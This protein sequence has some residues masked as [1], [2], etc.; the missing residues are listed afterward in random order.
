MLIVPTT[1]LRA[2]TSLSRLAELQDS[3]VSRHQLHEHGYDKDAIR[4]NVAARRWQ[5]IGRSV[6]VLHN[7]PLT[8]HQRKWAGVIGQTDGALAGLSAA[9]EFGFHGFDDDTVHIL[10][11]HGAR[12]RPLPGVKIHISRRF[13]SADLHPARTLPTVRI[14]RALADA[15]TWTTNERKASGILAAGVQQRLTTPDRLRAQLEIRPIVRHHRLLTQVIGDIEGGAHSFGEID[16]DRLARRA[17]LPTPRRQ[18]VRRDRNGKRRWL[19]ADFD[20]FSV[21]VD[22]ALHLRPLS[23]WD[24]MER[25][26][27]LVIVTGRPILRFSTVAF[28]IAEDTVIAQLAAAD[29]RFGREAE[30]GRQLAG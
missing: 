11:P 5:P 2:R 4:A 19:D 15:A 22:G 1:P 28:R 27:D 30:V 10:I 14:E 16:L 3:V 29:K 7:G 20:G 26:N 25:Q 13:S 9:V 21:E 23:Y 17:G 24:D 12:P 18:V 8:Q 6:V